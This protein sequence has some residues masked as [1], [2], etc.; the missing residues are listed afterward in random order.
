LTALL[1]PSLVTAR[2]RAAQLSSLSTMRSHTA[3]FTAYGTD[4]R[5]QWPFLNNPLATYTV[6]RPTPDL[7]LKSAYFGQSVEWPAGMAPAYYNGSLSPSVF[8]SPLAPA[9][10]RARAFSL[11]S[12]FVYGCVFVAHPEYWN[13]STRRAPRAQWVPT[14]VGGVRFP[15]AKV[16]LTDLAPTFARMVRN[17]PLPRVTNPVS[18]CDGHAALSSPDDRPPQSAQGDGPPS[19]EVISAGG[20]LGP[21]P[22]FSHTLDGIRGRDVP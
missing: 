2:E 7:A 19:A 9:D 10:M 16:I 8:V 17:A 3:V 12:S 5:D 13:P 20:H 1:V 6:H 11:H 15:D 18:F 4:Y 21:H 22:P 14:A